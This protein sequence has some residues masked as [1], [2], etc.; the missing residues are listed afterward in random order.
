MSM[1][2][3]RTLGLEALAFGRSSLIKLLDKT[4]DEHWLAQPLAGCNHVLWNVAHI[5]FVDN[6]C[7][8]MFG[9]QPSGVPAS[10]D[11]FFNMGST[12]FASGT[13]EASGY[14]APDE[15]RTVLTERR[16][17]LESWFK[18]LD[19]EGLAKALPEQMEGFAR[20]QVGL[21]GSLAVHEGM[22]IGQITM[23]RNALSLERCMG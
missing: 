20:N 9:G 11:P 6:M 13:A 17:A 12:P 16:S 10:W 4:P 1:E 23:V 5:A 21:L 3:A 18:S 8:T 7:V 22:H 2:S 19:E 14:P 15:V